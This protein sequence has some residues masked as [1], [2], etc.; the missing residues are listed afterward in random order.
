MATATAT[1]TVMGPTPA[2][3]AALASS[4]RLSAAAGLLNVATAEVVSAVAAALAD[5][6]WQGWGINSPEQWVALR[7]AMSAGRARRLV[8]MARALGDL[9]A[10]GA[11]FEEGVLSED[12]VHLLCRYV[13]PPHDAEVADLARFCTVGQLLRILPS[14]NPSEPEAT[15]EPAEPGSEPGAGDPGAGLG[16]EAGRREVCFGHGDDGRWRGRAL[17]EPDEGALVEKALEASRAALLA[18]H[19]GPPHQVGWADALVHLAEVALAGIEGT[20]RLPAD[21]YQV[22][23][24]LDAE[25]PERAR[26]HLGP[27][28]P[29]GLADY[30]SCDATGRVILNVGGTPTEILARRRSVDDRLRLLVERRDQGCRVPGCGRRRRLHVHHLVHWADGGPTVMANLCCLCPAHH[31][32]HHTGQLRIEG[33]PSGLDGLRFYDARGRPIRGPSP[34]P[35][36]DPPAEAAAAMGLPAP[37]YQPPTGERLET[38]WLHWT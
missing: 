29:K 9:P 3:E 8:A 13:D 4:K 10:T 27:L 1:A 37:R 30:L 20:G 28:L 16:D 24:H 17:L 19:D 15:P 22:V 11:A 5:D 33:D 12:Q 21:R 32:L 23:V 18:G 25:H 35:P 26:L 34:T 14:V 38:R 6:S 31:R 36:G 2:E 7:G